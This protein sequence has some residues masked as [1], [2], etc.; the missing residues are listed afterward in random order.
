MNWSTDTYHLRICVDCAAMAANGDVGDRGDI[1]DLPEHAQDADDAHLYN[2][3]GDDAEHNANS[4]HAARMD[5]YTGG[6]VIAPG[7]GEGEF[8]WRSCDGCGSSL[9][10]SRFEATGFAR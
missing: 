3:P 7:D 8:S 1:G 5:A 2:L 10:G 9:G 6:L 4:R